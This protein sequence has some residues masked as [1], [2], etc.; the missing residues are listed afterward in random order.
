VSPW[1]HWRA[2]R[3]SLNCLLATQIAAWRKLVFEHEIGTAGAT[4]HTIE[5]A[6]S[7][8]RAIEAIYR[9]KRTSLAPQGHKIFPHLLHNVLIVRPNQLWATD[10]TYLPVARGF[11]YRVAILDLYSRKV[12]ALRESNA[13]TS[14]FCVE[15]LQEALVR[16]GAPE[17]SNSDQGSPF[18]D[19]QFTAPL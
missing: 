6:G 17:I 4:G 19:D 12:L 5:Y 10:I 11:A 3:H 14:E 2:R 1:R 18:T 9:K 13:M 8:I 15:A 7:G 16:F